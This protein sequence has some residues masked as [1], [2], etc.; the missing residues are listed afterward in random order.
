MLFQSLCA[1]ALVAFALPSFVLGSAIPRDVSDIDAGVTLATLEPQFFALD[2]ITAREAL[3]EDIDTPHLAAR[4]LTA[5]E[6]ESFRIHN[7]ARKEKGLK[8]LVWDQKLWQDALAYAKVLAKKGRLEH[9]TNRNGQGENL[10]FV[11]YVTDY[12]RGSRH[13]LID[14]A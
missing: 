9:S 14:G 10:G 12:T 2:T 5:D 13:S 1:Q 4:A 11:R 3:E 6:A 7:A 8:P